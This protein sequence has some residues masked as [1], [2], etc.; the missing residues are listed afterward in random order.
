MLLYSIEV[1]C[2]DLTLSLDTSICCRSSPEKKKKNPYPGVSAMV[3][4]VKSPTTAAQVTVEAQVRSSARHSE[5]KYL[6]M[7]LL[8]H[9]S[10]L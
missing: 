3:L 4:W 10:Q 5:L 1:F 2:Q 9:W 7:L 8:S 6:A